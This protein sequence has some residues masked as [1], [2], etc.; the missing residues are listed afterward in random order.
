MPIDNSTSQFTGTLDGE[1]HI[2]SS[3]TINRP[4]SEYVGLLSYVGTGAAV[5]N[6][7]L[8]GGSVS[9]NLAVG[10][11]A[12]YNS[13]TVTQSYATGTVSGTNEVGGLVGVNWYGTITQSYGAGAASSSTYDVG[14]LA[15]MSFEGAITQSHATGMVSGEYRV[16]GL[17]GANFYTTIDQ[18]YAT[19]EVNGAQLVGGLVGD[20]LY[21]T[22]RQSYAT[23]A[24]SGTSYE[25]G[26]LV[27]WNGAGTITQSYATGAVSGGQ[28]VGGLVGQNED[29]I[30]QSYATG[31]VSGTSGV[32]G[33]VGTNVFSGVISQSYWDT[34][35]SDQNS[36][37]GTDT[38]NQSSNITGLTSVQARMQSSYVGWDFAG[39]WFMIDGETRPFGQWEYSTTIMNAHQLQLMA[40]DLSANYTLAND[41][42]LGPALAADTNGNYAGMWG[43][44]GFVP[45]GNSVSNFTGTLDGQGHTISNLIINFPSATDVG[46]I[47]ATD[48]NAIV[49][50]VEVT[51]A[52]VMGYNV[53]G[54]LVGYNNGT[55]AS[56]NVSGTVTGS[57]I[58][59]GGPTS[60]DTGGLVGHNAG[61][62]TDSSASVTVASGQGVG[63]LAGSNFGTI[64]TFL[65][66]WF[67]F[68]VKTA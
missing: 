31:A 63:G 20:N 58:E 8:L 55:I 3:L 59:S 37:I 45:V 30:S 34:Q 29:V 26:G 50:N 11:L 2:I 42:D 1:N 57:L 33:L 22:I 54:G 53:I 56:S 47:G 25:I 68:R 7:A 39:T 60:G 6:I 10:D 35:T 46:L 9:G 52:N 4:S 27:G 65:C 43:A 13:G 44:G 12:G 41:I 5:R 51:N 24:V 36:G 19:G 28:D 16:G 64:S 17:V 48:T 38:N 49:R 23:G 15:G 61:T 32:G 18:S 66:E 14:G 67:S 62:I 40:M 21:S